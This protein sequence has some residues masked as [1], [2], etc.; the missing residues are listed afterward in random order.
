VIDSLGR[1]QS[2]LVL[3]GTSE[4]GSAV[5]HAFAEQGRLRRVILA[6]RNPGALEQTAAEVR[7][8]ARAEVTVDHLEATDPSSLV[9]VVDRAF[10]GGDVDIVLL[11]LGVLEDQRSLEENPEGAFA[12]A[13]T[14]FAAPVVLG[15]AAARR[16]RAQGHGT[17][18]VLSSVAGMRPRRSNYVYGSTKAGLDTFARGLDE[19]L[20]GSGARVLVVRPGFVRSRMTNGLRAAPFATTPQAVADVVVDAVAHNRRLVFAPGVVRGVMGVLTRLP[21][22]VFRRLPD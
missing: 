5:V 4:I 13:A 2:V 12:V 15:L 21:Q 18:I 20:R 6:G 7:T 17:L 14:N 8:T 16:L 11:A 9:S 3:G 19:A 1:P 22:Q 10:D